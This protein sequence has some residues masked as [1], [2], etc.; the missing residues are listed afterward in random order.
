MWRK[1]E[2]PQHLCISRA[3]AGPGACSLADSTTHIDSG[4]IQAEEV[5]QSNILARFDGG[6]LLP[7]Y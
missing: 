5:K 6:H 3:G 2:T 4:A 7:C 1:N